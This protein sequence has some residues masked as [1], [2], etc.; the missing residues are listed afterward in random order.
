MDTGSNLLGSGL[1]LQTPVLVS[2]SHS[3]PSAASMEAIEMTQM[4]SNKNGTAVH[5]TVQVSPSIIVINY[6]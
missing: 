2:N 1:G 6:K 5:T 3:S 4:L